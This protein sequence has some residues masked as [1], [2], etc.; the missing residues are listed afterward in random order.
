MYKNHDYSPDSISFYNKL[1]KI[2]RNLRKFPPVPEPSVFVK[3]VKFIKM[4]SE[5][6]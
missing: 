5:R 6:Q 1:P 3:V 2:L 4:P